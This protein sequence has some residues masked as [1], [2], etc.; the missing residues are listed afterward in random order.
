[1][2]LEYSP[3]GVFENSPTVN[4]IDRRMPV[5]KYT[6][7]VS[8]GLLTLRTSKL[9]LRYKVGSGAFTPGETFTFDDEAEQDVLGP[10]ALMAEKAY[11]SWARTRTLRERSVNRSNVAQV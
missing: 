9:T 2:R 8:G 6:A 10:D 11:L 4:V 3:S 7:Q 5:P 1:V